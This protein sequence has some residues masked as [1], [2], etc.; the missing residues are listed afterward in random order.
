M[1]IIVL[2][3]GIGSGKTTATE[4]FSSKNIPIIDT[5]IISRELVEKNKAAY[6]EIIQAFG[7]SIL[8]KNRNINRQALRDLVFSSAVHRLQLENI[9][10]PKIWQEVS[11][12]I[13]T[14]T[15][16]TNPPPYTIVVV[17]LYFETSQTIVKFDRVLVIDANESTQLERTKKRD[18]CTEQQVE[19]I[20]SHQVSRETRLKSANDIISNNETLEVLKDKIEQ[21]H[22]YYLS[23]V[24]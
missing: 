9:L 11:K 6:T 3:G 5:D 10:H 24:K 13:T 4:I 2:T 1:L 21:Q 16:L 8:D 19:K 7:D 14:I 15:V 22:Q 18:H 17:P 12:Q 23:L 20:I